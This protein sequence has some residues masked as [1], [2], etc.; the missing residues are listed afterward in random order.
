MRIIS[1]QKLIRLIK[2]APVLVVGIFIV[3]LSTIIIYNNHTKAESDLAS[4][5]DNFL[6]RQKA[7]AKSQVEQVFQDILFEQHQAEATLKSDIK[8]R[9]GEAYAIAESIYQ[10]HK[11]KPEAEV[12]RLITT[13][14]RNISFN[15]GRGYFFIY[16]TN[17]L[18]VMH[19]LLPHIEGQ[20]K[21]DLQDVKG[22][23]IVREMGELVKT[24]GEDF[25][26]WWFVKPQNKTQEFEKIGYGKYFAPYDWFIGTGEYVIDVENDIKQRLLQRI[27][28][29]RYGENGYVF[30]IDYQGNYLSHF[31]KSL[32][33]TNNVDGKG[34]NGFPFVRKIIKT[35]QQGGGYVQYVSSIMPSSGK[36]AQKI[37]Y[38][39]GVTDWNWVVGTGVYIKE[40]ENYLTKREAVIQAQNKDELRK[41]LLLSISATLILIFVLIY[42]SRNIAKRFQNFQQHI[43]SSIKELQHTKDQLHFLAHHDTLT[44]LPNRLLLTE[45][46]AR[47]IQLS[48]N[49]HT[50]FALMFVDLDDFKKI[51]DLYS[52]SI[53]D[54]LLQAVTNRFQDVLQ[55]GDSITRFGGDEFIFCFPGLKD[56]R[57]AEEKV[58]LIHAI[59]KKPF[60]I[61][62]KVIH[63][64]CSIGVTMYPNDGD[65][66]EELISKA[67]IVLHKS[68]AHQ[69]GSVLFFNKSV[70]QQVHRDLQLESALRMALKNHELSVVYQ[71]QIC[72]K[73]GHIHGVEALVR[74]HNKQLGHVS[75]VDFIHIAESSGLIHEIGM[76]VLEQSL[77]D[78]SSFNQHREHPIMLSVNLSPKQLNAPEFVDHIMAAVDRHSLDNRLITFEITESLLIEDLSH[79][80]PILQR[81][82]DSGFNLSLDDFGT[83]Y[84]SLSYLNI[85]P[86][87][88][89]KIDR[90]FIEK[91]LSSSETDNLIRAIIAIGESYQL[92][93]VAEGVETAEQLAKLGS[94]QCHIAQGYY[95]DKPLPLATLCD[96]YFT[97][98]CC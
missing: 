40:V 72:I 50:Q 97:T 68:K 80:S 79:V 7:V 19:P 87:N 98:T 54:S 60:A 92:T 39:K 74:W 21:W 29:I 25:Y 2:V 5:R 70:N 15:G 41:I 31:K 52:H 3:L 69:K 71:P 6:D 27:S 18:N 64:S 83:G 26:H 67:D 11:D 17:G 73:S 94:Y 10:Q 63:S 14:L 38:V 65:D 93:M 56:I 55:E 51:N 62:G 84:S 49:N 8:Q 47:A 36:P 12:T 42:I 43:G 82:R 16:K 88:E 46:I 58:K 13:S 76:F 57:A 48:K 81:L 24:N 33:G 61:S 89:I 77:S 59:F 91:L 96:K 23:Y 9:V 35:A 90:S 34:A 22:S 45:R 20:S 66:P 95:F 44:Q 86:I 85:L 37:S 32:V 53:G 1:D 4:L 78:I 28:N 30:V 75:P